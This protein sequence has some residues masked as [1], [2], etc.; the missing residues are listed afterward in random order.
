MNERKP[1]LLEVRIE[2]EG[3]EDIPLAHRDERDGINKTQEASALLEQQIEASV[4]ED[5]VDP[6]HGDERR[7]VRPKVSDGVETEAP[8]DERIC[9]DQNERRRHE[10]RLPRPQGGECALSTGVV[11]VCPIEQREQPGGICED[12][13]HS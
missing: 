7:E 13:S 10:R 8:A 3:F 12:G 9:F 1:L 6:H 5:F 11:L 4:M 2:R